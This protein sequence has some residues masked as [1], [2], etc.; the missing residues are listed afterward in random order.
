M[1]TLVDQISKTKARSGNTDLEK[2]ADF[3]RDKTPQDLDTPSHLAERRQFLRD[4]LGSAKASKEL[5]ER[6]IAGNE[7]QDINYPFRG[8]RAAKAVARLLCALK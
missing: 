1:S 6:I 5:F 4:S 2:L 8:A 7:I 3:A